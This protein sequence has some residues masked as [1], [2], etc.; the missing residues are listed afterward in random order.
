[1][2]YVKIPKTENLIEERPPGAAGPA[3][4]RS[5]PYPYVKFLEENVWSRHEWRQNQDFASAWIRLT[6]LFEEAKELEIVGLSDSDYEK[7]FPLA[8]MKDVNLAPGVNG[9]VITRYT[10]AAIYATSE[11]PEGYV[12]PKQLPAEKEAPQLSSSTV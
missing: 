1:M 12:A 8:T 5:L 6:A 9:R 2:R 3:V 10:H 11:A 7:W 4:V